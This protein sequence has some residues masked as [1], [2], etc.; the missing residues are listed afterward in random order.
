MEK[1]IQGF[2]NYSINPNGQ[3]KNIKT[4]LTLKAKKSKMGYEEIQLRDSNHKSKWFLVHRLVAEYFCGGQ[5]DG[6]V[7]NHIDGDKLNNNASNLEW[8]TQSENLKHAYETGLRK[9]DTSAKRIVATNIQT[10]EQ[11]VFDSIHKASKMT[12]FSRGNICL[13]CQ[14][15]RPYANGYYWSYDNQS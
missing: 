4:G 10:G 7:V 13:C 14:N 2:E 3:I 9:K 12:G 11:L 6:M 5:Q 15:K 1:I 8:V